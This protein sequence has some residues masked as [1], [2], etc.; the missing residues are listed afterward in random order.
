VGSD[1]PIQGRAH[2]YFRVRAILYLML[3]R[4]P[5][6]PLTVESTEVTRLLI[7]VIKINS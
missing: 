7:V 2:S 3:L 5:K 4:L 6:N 1:M